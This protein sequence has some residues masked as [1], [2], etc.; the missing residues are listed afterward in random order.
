MTILTI[1]E[2]QMRRLMTDLAHVEKQF[3]Q[4]RYYM[5][6]VREDGIDEVILLNRRPHTMKTLS[7]HQVQWY[8]DTW[9]T[10]EH[11]AI[12]VEYPD[13]KLVIGFWADD[14]D[15]VIEWMKGEL[16]DVDTTSL[17]KGLQ[18]GQMGLAS[19]VHTAT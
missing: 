8:H 6:W 13:R 3:H 18:L 1:Q 4:L 16:K 17:T 12:Q 9:F 11:V 15:N 7:K 19:V 5:F 10:I 14:I 2:W